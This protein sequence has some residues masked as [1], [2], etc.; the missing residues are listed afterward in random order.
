MKVFK[1]KHQF[2]KN[3]IVLVDE[4]TV[5]EQ[6]EGWKEVMRLAQ[7]HGLIGFAGGGVAVLISPRV[8]LE[9]KDYHRIQVACGTRHR[10]Q[11]VLKSDWISN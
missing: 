9:E 5:L 11:E 4:R 10:C 8:Q 7:K 2:D 6:S 1:T 3:K